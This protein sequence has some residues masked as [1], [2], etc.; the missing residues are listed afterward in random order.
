[1]KENGDEGGVQQQQKQRKE[2]LPLIRESE[3]STMD[4]QQYQHQKRELSPLKNEQ[5]HQHQQQQQKKRDFPLS[6]PLKMDVL[7]CPICKDKFRTIP[8]G[9]LNRT[10]IIITQ[11]RD[12][13]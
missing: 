9:K 7:I 3:L 11:I 13:I 2:L 12:F 6:T 1:M 8:I 4:P 5:Q 10:V